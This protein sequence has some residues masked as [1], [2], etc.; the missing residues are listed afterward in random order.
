[1]SSLTNTQH[2]DKDAAIGVFDSGIGGL[3][4]LKHLRAQLPKEK[5][6][7]IADSDYTPYG[8]KSDEEIIARCIKITD[9]F[10]AQNIKALVVA[11]NTA[12]AAAA[13]VLRQRYPELI[14]VAM[15]PG[16]KP[17]A[18]HS[19]SKV[20]GVL[21]TQSTLRSN[22][23]KLLQQ[24]LSQETQ[25]QFIPQACVGLVNEIEKGNLAANEIIELIHR[26]VP[27]LLA[28]NVDHLVLGCTHYPFVAHI[29]EKLIVETLGTAHN[30]KLI[31]TGEAV[32]RRL[33]HLLET[34]KLLGSSGENE[35]L[36][37][38]TGSTSTLQLAL[39]FVMDTTDVLA[40]SVSL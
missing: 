37:R 18:L 33:A 6:L 29:I 38:A 26:Y 23:F 40:Q 20:V 11:C 28:Q 21:A 1:M 31:D 7:Y 39:S 36:A 27:P 10:I 3:S 22:K 25:V 16:L 34:K 35:V 13:A 17:A 12:T 2:F 32:A 4:V 30:V 9:F 24:T 14:L 8:E 19:Q 15:E 5:W